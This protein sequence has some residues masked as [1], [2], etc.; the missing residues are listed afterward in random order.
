[1]GDAGPAT[2][3][4]CSRPG[5]S[6][7]APDANACVGG[8]P[9]AADLAVPAPAVAAGNS[10]SR[11]APTPAGDADAV[12]A[13]SASG[14]PASHAG[15]HQRPPA[16][17][18]RVGPYADR[19]RPRR[20]ACGGEDPRRREAA[21]ITLDAAPRGAPAATVST[22]APAPATEH[23]RPRPRRLRQ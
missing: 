21:V 16:W 12:I 5:A 23:P 3:R 19:R 7:T 18:V 8:N 6:V 20:R 4:R 11:S 15:H 2:R 22:P 10:R 1:V 17:R 14:C 9:D 13:Y